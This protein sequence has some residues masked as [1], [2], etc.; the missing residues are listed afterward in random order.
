MTL[1]ADYMLLQLFS[2]VTHRHRVAVDTLG[3]ERAFWRAKFEEQLHSV[4]ITDGLLTLQTHKLAVLNRL[5]QVY[6]AP[7]MLA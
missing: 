4:L 7:P 6:F 5:W 1:K 3:G 2:A